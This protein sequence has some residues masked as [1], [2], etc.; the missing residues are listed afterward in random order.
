MPKNSLFTKLQIGCLV[1]LLF[2]ASVAIYWPG[3]DGSFFF[4]DGPSI[5]KAEGVQ[6]HTLTVDALRQAWLSGG[7]GPTGRPVAQ[8]SFALNYYFSGFSPFAFKATNLGIHLACGL[9]IFTLTRLL[10][11]QAQPLA[12]RHHLFL[13]TSAV[14]VL[15]LLHPIQLLPVLHVVQRMTSLSA[16]FLLFAFWLHIGGRQRG[17]LMGIFMLISGWVLVWPLSILSKETGALFPLTVLA[18]ELILRRSMQG[19]L[20]RFARVFTILVGFCM[21]AVMVYALS[22]RAQWLWAGYSMRSFS[23]IERL[24]T[25]GRVLWFYLYLIVA[26]RLEML[27]LYHDDI[28]IST[29]LLT[30]W[31]TLPALGGLIGLIWLAWHLRRRAPV[32]AFG[33]AWFFISHMLESTAL[34][35]EIAHEHRNYLPLF[36][37]LLAGGSLLLTVLA[38]KGASKTLALG[39]TSAALIYF[40]FVTALRANQFAEEGRRTQI[41]AQHHRKSAHA[42]YDAGL[43]LAGLPEA[44]QPNSPTRAF[45]RRHFEISNTL[46]PNSKL[47]WLSLIYLD[48]N[49]GLAADLTEVSELEHRLR[50]TPFGPADSNVLFGLKEMSVEGTLCLTR[51]QVDGLFAAALANPT[52]SAGVPAILHS[53]H[54]D[55]LWLSEHD[56]PAAR[57]ALSQSL[58]LNP[59]NPSN[60]LKWAQLLVISGEKNDARKL[61]LKLRGEN[62]SADERKTFN[63]LL[64]ADNMTGH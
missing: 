57:T 32:I 14:T 12:K 1:S 40:P 56:M 22:A 4:D 39:L 64:A 13:A 31:T 58:A 34:P 52:V 43:I 26:P 61:L 35:L 27:G 24:L 7:A 54:A 9:L 59:G 16:F 18:W 17:G 60:R 36:G 63:E 47:G 5:L 23:L 2:V 28:A 45:A 19:H 42:Q 53:W 21:V 3:L 38:Q 6:L 20:D 51:E 62:Y 44:A 15:W 48:C 50:S 49:A 30:P 8:L 46:D 25:E 41:E 37:I 29:G 10:L 11:T 55:Y 33:I